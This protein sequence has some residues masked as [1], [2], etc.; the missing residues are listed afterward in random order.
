M[1]QELPRIQPCSVPAF[2]RAIGLNPR[3]SG[4]PSA[5]YA[6]I[7][8][9]FKLGLEDGRLTQNGRNAWRVAGKSD[10]RGERRAS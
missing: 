8:A 1:V 6:R 5:D 7:L 3:P 9:A 4:V 10:E 2:M